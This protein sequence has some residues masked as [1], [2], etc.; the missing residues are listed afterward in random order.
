V[1]SDPDARSLI[2]WPETDDTPSADQFFKRARMNFGKQLIVH[3]LYKVI[4]CVPYKF[5]NGPLDSLINVHPVQKLKKLGKKYRKWFL[6]IIPESCLIH[7]K[8]ILTSF[9]SIPVALIWY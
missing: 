9:L 2:G 4:T 3:C 8:F 5:F 1:S 6:V 7:R